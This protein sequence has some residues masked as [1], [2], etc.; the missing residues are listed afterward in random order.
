MG[1]AG[2]FWTGSRVQSTAPIVAYQFNPLDNVDVF[3][4]DASLLIPANTFGKEYLV[5]SRFQFTGGG[6]DIPLGSSCAQVC[7]QI[8][9]GECVFDGTDDVCQFPYRGTIS[10]VAAGANTTVTVRPTARTAAGATMSAMVPGQSYEVTLEPFQ[11]LNIRSDEEGADLTGT[12]IVADKP[13]GV[14][15]G[16]MAALSGEKCC[17]DHLEQMMFPV[18][19]WG[20]TYVCT[21]SFPRNQESD[22]WRILAAEDGTVVQFE[23]GVAVNQALDRGEYFE[24]ATTQDFKITATKPVLVAQILASAREAPGNSY[25][26]DAYDCGFDEFCATTQTCIR[27]CDSEFDTT[28]CG[29]GTICT[30]SDPTFCYCESVGDP[31]LILAAPVEQFRQDYVFLTPNAYRDDYINVIAPAAAAVTLDGDAVPAGQFTAI[32][33]SGYKVA[34]LV[35]SDG[36]H[37]LSATDKVSVIAY[38]YDRHVSYGYAA[39]LNLN[40]L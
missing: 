23:P 1:K 32:P 10:V 17:A 8:D 27:Y 21:K 24:F 28:S 30:C 6:P 22:Y 25:C 31:A 7:G 5:M 18:T 33:G 20:K 14:F 40:D 4:N 11:V 19:T 15:S 3:S 29:Q 9:G 37:T 12:E 35:V 34:R 38:G 13:V 2:T 16:H 36:V 26:A 39:G